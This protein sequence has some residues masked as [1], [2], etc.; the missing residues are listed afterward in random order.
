[1]MARPVR[2][3]VRPL[4]RYVNVV[5]VANS[6]GVAPAVIFTRPAIGPSPV[7]YPES[8]H[9]PS[10]F[11]LRMV[12]DHA[13]HSGVRS[14]NA[15]FRCASAL[16]MGWRLSGGRPSGPGWLDGGPNRRNT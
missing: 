1:M 3:T 4:L 2:V 16:S 14:G 13:D 10:I 7:S 12:A 6:S 8:A 5:S 11:G 9:V 15:D